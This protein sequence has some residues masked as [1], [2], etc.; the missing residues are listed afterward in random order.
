MPIQ[1]F[2]YM[3][4]RLTELEFKI[5]YD[6]RCS[7]DRVFRMKITSV[8]YVNINIDRLSYVRCII[9]EMNFYEWP[10]SYFVGNVQIEFMNILLLLL[11]IYLYYIIINSPYVMNLGTLTSR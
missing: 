8:G 9:I 7:N 4:H 10:Q 11:V 6:F 1:Q 2:F 3:T 5:Y